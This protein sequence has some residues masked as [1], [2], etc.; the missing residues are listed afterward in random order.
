MLENCVFVLTVIAF[1]GLIFAVVTYCI[2]RVGDRKETTSEITHVEYVNGLSLR[3]YSVCTSV[4]IRKVYD[5]KKRAFTGELEECAFF[6]SYATPDSLRTNCSTEIFI[7][8]PVGSCPWHV[9]DLVKTEGQY[10]ENLVES[11]SDVELKC[12]DSDTGEKVVCLSED[13][14]TRLYKIGGRH[15]SI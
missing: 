12:Y 15:D 10:I 3:S 13:W 14:F 11:S 7:A 2:R 9:G 5:Y 6:R 8:Y 4:E 1:L